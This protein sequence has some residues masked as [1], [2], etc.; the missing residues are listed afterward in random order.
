MMRNEDALLA[1]VMD[2]FA[3]RFDKH[4]VLR[5]GMALR[6][7]GCERL[8]NDVDYFFV[9]YRSKKQIVAGIFTI[10]GSI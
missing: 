7:L 4:A 6:I 3:R 2:L 1:R 8:T 9:P 10:S 5:G